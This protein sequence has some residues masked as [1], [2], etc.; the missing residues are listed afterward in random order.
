MEPGNLPKSNAFSGILGNCLKSTFSSLVFQG[1]AMVQAVSRRPVTTALLG[2]CWVSGE[3][4][5]CRTGVLTAWSFTVYSG[6]KGEEVGS[7]GIFEQELCFFGNRG[8]T[9]KWN[10]CIAFCHSLKGSVPVRPD[11]HSDTPMSPSPSCFIAPL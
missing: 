1:R 4:S 7:L 8:A 11:A 9:S 3:R 6:H 10:S 5:S 2:L